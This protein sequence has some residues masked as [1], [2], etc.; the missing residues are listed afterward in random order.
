MSEHPVLLVGLS[1]I[2]SSGKTT[3]AR[4]LLKLL[5]NSYLIHQDDFYFPDKDLPQSANGTV[6]WDSIEAIDF[7]R[8][9]EELLHCKEHGK[10]SPQHISLQDANAFTDLPIDNEIVAGLASRIATMGLTTNS[11]MSIC[12]MDGFLLYAEDLAAIKD[13]LDVRLFMHTDY[14]TA[15]TR[16]AARAGY[17]TYDGFWTDPPGYFDE[18]VWPNYTRYHSY[19]FHDRDASGELDVESCNELGIQVPPRHA[20]NDM[21]ACLQWACNAILDAAEKIK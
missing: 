15:K 13:I 3:L 21:N 5:P 6:D 8:L 9:K 17:T 12:I 7:V 1:G 2:S 10:P 14:E 19:M 11:Y 18:I 16:R 20:Q 4:L